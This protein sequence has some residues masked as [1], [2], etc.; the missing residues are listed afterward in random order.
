MY[1]KVVHKDLI[2]TIVSGDMRKFVRAPEWLEAL[3]FGPVV[4]DETYKLSSKKGAKWN[5]L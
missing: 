3:G 2:S 4:F 1:Y 5:E